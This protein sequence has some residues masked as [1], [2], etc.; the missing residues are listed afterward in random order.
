VD[1]LEQEE[2]DNSRPTLIYLHGYIEH[3]LMESV[4]VIAEAYLKR[5]DHSTKFEARCTQNEN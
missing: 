2:F 1:I 3:M 5:D 4:R